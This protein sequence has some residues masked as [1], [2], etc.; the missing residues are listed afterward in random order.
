MRTAVLI[1]VAL[2]VGC[3]NGTNFYLDKVEKLEAKVSQLEKGIELKDAEI[4]ILR[5]I[6][7]ADQILDNVGGFDRQEMEALCNMYE[8]EINFKNELNAAA[9]RDVKNEYDKT[10]A[11]ESP[12]TARDYCKLYE[13]KTARM[14][15]R[16]ETTKKYAQNSKKRLESFGLDSDK[17]AKKTVDVHKH[18][19]PSIDCKTYYDQLRKK[20]SIK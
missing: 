6:T 11:N 19:L 7:D 20:Y 9:A 14:I 12:L 4:K 3:E 10:K 15:D 18:I 2:L 13:E 8:K 1:V 17:A 16:N 5:N